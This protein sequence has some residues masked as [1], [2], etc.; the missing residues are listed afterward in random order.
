MT[1]SE[2]GRRAQ[3]NASNGTDHGTAAP[4][5]L[6]GSGVKGGLY[7]DAPDLNNLDNGNLRHSIDFR[8]VYATVIE[9]WLQADS[10]TILGG[11]YPT[12]AAVG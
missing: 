8:S 2:F 5:F 7:G 11:T 6:V 3:Q 12:L 4:L 1:W 10:K 9:R